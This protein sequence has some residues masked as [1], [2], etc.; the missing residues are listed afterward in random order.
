MNAGAAYVFRFD[1]SAWVEEQ[2]LTASDAQSGD[3]FG[4]AVSLDGDLAVVGAYFDDDQGAQSGSAY[5]FHFDGKS[6][7]EQQKILPSDGAARDTFGKSL[8]LSGDL[9]LV[10]AC[11]AAYVFRFDGTRWTEEQ[12]LTDPEAG[13]ERDYGSAVAVLGVRSLRLL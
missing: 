6:W 13:C 12:K 11:G 9:L 7:V 2:Q 8:A 4:R 1:G 10:A 3:Q 5:V